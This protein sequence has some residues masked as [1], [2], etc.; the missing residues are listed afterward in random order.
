L[1]KFREVDPGKDQAL[2]RILHLEIVAFDKGEFLFP[3]PMERG[4]WI[5]FFISRLRSLVS[6]L[7]VDNISYLRRNFINSCISILRRNKMCFD[8][9]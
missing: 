5:T 7:M 9:F 2:C 1:D 6:I 8:I 3:E 4:H